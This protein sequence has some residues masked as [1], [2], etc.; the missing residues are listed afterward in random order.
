MFTAYTNI[1][2]FFR[3][4]FL[5]L[6]VFSICIV[7][8]I[9]FSY[10]IIVVNLYGTAHGKKKKNCFWFLC[11]QHILIYI[12]IFLVLAFVFTGVF[13]LYS[14]GYFFFSYITIVVNLYGTA[15]WKN[16]QLYNY[17][18]FWFCVYNIYPYFLFFYFA[19]VFVFIGWC[20]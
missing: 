16:N 10:I 12:Y 9:F 2:L 6:L 4:W 18:F 5:C 7:L 20:F 15:H 3:F 19:F 1:Y 14:I 13:N 11:L 8:V 17:F